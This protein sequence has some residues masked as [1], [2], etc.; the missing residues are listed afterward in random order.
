MMPRSLT[1]TSSPHYNN[2]ISTDKLCFNTNL[3]THYLNCLSQLPNN[4]YEVVH[5]LQIF[6]KFTEP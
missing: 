4:V 2:R 3:N 1:R 5:V 6:M